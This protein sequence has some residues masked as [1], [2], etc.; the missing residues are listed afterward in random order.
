MPEAGRGEQEHGSA[1][2]REHDRDGQRAD[3]PRG[4]LPHRGSEIVRAGSAE[5]LRAHAWPEEEPAEDGKDRGDERHGDQEGDRGRDRE[6]RPERAE[7]L[8]LAG[9]ESGCAGNDDQ[10][11]SGDDGCHAHRRCARGFHPAH[12]LEQASAATG[13]IEDGVVGDDAECERDHEWLDLLR[14]RHAHTLADP[15]DH[16]ARDEKGDSRG[17]EREQRR[18]E[19]TEGESDDEEDERDGGSFDEREMARD[20]P[21]LAQSRGRGPRDADEGIARLVDPPGV[22]LR[23][24]DAVGEGRLRSEEQI[25]EGGRSAFS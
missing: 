6:A 17:E 18:P 13:E 10:A 12:A 16:A 4:G 1:E 11:G 15:G 9:Q 14:H 24:V 8:E 21:K 3:E 25:G 5:V 20:L 23:L 22:E 19:R 2:H 7:D